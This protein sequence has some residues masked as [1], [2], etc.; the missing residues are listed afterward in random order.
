MVEGNAMC[1]VGTGTPSRRMQTCAV[2]IRLQQRSAFE[3]RV[4]NDLP[5]HSNES[6]SPVHPMPTNA[7]RLQPTP[8]IR[9]EHLGLGL[10]RRRRVHMRGRVKLILR[11][12]P[13]HRSC[14]AHPSTIPSA[15]S[16]FSSASHKWE[17]TDSQGRV[18][19]GEQRLSLESVCACISIH[20]HPSSSGSMGGHSL[21][22]VHA[23]PT[24]RPCTA[25]RL[26]VGAESRVHLR[27]VSF[28]IGVEVP[29]RDL[30]SW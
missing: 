8:S 24:N 30:S 4:K 6:P 9:R 5:P 18:D 15:E 27:P 22:I 3:V 19:I 23:L 25:A 29:T 1:D 12:P 10:R 26:K 7:S 13:E 11:A 2:C 20:G 14:S 16:R 17:S 28:E 21:N